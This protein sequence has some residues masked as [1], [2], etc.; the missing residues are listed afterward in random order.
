MLFLL[1]FVVVNVA[2]A[3]FVATCTTRPYVHAQEFCDPIGS[4]NHRYP[5]NRAYTDARSD[6]SLRLFEEGDFLTESQRSSL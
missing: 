2:I 3:V 1:I 5:G 4:L 6:R